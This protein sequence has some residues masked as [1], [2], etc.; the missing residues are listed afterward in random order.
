M[1]CMVHIRKAKKFNGCTS[2]EK[3]KCY[4]KDKRNPRKHDTASLKELFSNVS[5]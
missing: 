1:P 2:S 4:G 3:G 5:V